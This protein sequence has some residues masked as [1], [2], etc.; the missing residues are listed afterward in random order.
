MSVSFILSTVALSVG[1]IVLGWSI[2]IQ[3]QVNAINNNNGGGEFYS[4]QIIGLYYGS[5]HN[6][7]VN[8]STSISS[9]SNVYQYVAIMRG[10]QVFLSDETGDPSNLLI[11]RHGH[12]YR[13]CV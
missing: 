11:L 6:V 9:N 2:G 10:L 4:P 7:R 3:V 1:I 13:Q 5:N 12:C 8:I